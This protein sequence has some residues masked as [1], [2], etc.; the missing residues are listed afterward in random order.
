MEGCETVVTFGSTMGI[1]APYWGK[2]RI[3]SGRAEYENLGAVEV[4]AT[5]DDL[6]VKI[7]AKLEPASPHLAY[8]YGV[9]RKEIGI[10]FTISTLRFPSHPLVRGQKVSKIWLNTM[11]I[12][13][14]TVRRSQRKT[15]SFLIKLKSRKSVFYKSFTTKNKMLQEVK[16]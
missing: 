4:V 11:I 7:N 3:L 2:P 12:G 15:K 14:K 9:Y 5:I 1:E 16:G 6:I 10:P 8:P 13:W